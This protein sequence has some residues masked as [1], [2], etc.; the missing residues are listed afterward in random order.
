MWHGKWGATM[1]KIPN[2]YE[3]EVLSF[4]R[5]N[6]KD[7]V[8]AVFN[9]SDKE[10]IVEFKESLYFGNYN[11][12]ISNESVELNKNTKIEMEPWAFRVYVKQ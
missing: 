8:F 5:Q 11:D 7:K 10:K 12:F 6:E 1:I 2:N 4:V 3:T 9:F